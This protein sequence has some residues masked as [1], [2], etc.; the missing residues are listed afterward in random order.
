MLQAIQRKTENALSSQQHKSSRKVMPSRD[1][2]LQQ[3]C[4]SR[5][6]FQVSSGGMHPLF[7]IKGKL[8]PQ[9]FDGQGKLRAGGRHDNLEEGMITCSLKFVQIGVIGNFQHFSRF[10]RNPALGLARMQMCRFPV[11]SLQYTG[12]RCSFHTRGLTPPGHGEG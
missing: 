9:S 2:S 11:S 7:A 4:G 3:S 1:L 5:P 12:K 8:A 6:T 10:C